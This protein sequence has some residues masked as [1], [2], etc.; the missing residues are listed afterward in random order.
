[1]L[2]EELNNTHIVEKG[3]FRPET[4]K[5]CC[6]EMHTFRVDSMLSCID[7]GVYQVNKVNDANYLEFSR[8]SISHNA[9]IV[10]VISNENTPLVI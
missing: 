3:G 2:T 9:N 8:L 1:M 5:V 10:W 4:I 7:A 6:M